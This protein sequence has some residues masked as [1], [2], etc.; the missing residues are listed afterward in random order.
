MRCPLCGDSSTTTVSGGGFFDCPGCH[1]VFR[2]P[3]ARLGADAELGHYQTHQN[4]PADE[5]YRR[6]LSRLADPLIE[7]LPPGAEGLDYGSGPGPTLSVI[8]EE[9]GFPMEIFD[10]FFAPDRAVLDR[11]YDFVTCTETAEHF[12]DPAAEFTRLAG[13]LKSGGWL[14]VMT[15][16]L[17][18]DQ[19]IGEWWY[20]RDPTHVAFYRE[21]TLRWIA[22]HFGWAIF[23]PEDNVVLFHRTE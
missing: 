6:F 5:R 18:D 10:P 9:R 7:R 11:Q 20:A 14:G 21:T 13:L 16:V 2:D 15:G 12:F 8:L 4:S 19:P 3:S 1:L 22:G 23:R 17:P